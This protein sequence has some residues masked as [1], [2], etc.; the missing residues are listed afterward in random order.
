MHKFKTRKSAKEGITN[1][2]INEDNSTTLLR[3]LV[4]SY[5]KTKAIIEVNG[6]DAKTAPQKPLRLAIS[7]IKT[8]RIAEM[9]TFKKYCIW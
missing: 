7:D 3:S 8:I 5:R 1:Q 4:S 2:K 6:M 9:T